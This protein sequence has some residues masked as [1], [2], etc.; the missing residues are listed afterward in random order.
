VDEIAI[1]VAEPRLAHHPLNIHSFELGFLC[2]AFNRLVLHLRL[3]NKIAIITGAGSGIGKA[4]TLAFSREGAKVTVA[5][6]QLERLK[7]TVRAVQELG[8]EAIAVQADISKVE[9]VKELVE[10]CVNAF[11]KLDL[12]YNNAGYG[13][14]GSITDAE[15]DSWDQVLNTNLKGTFMCSKYAIREIKKQGSGSVINTSSVMGLTGGP[16]SVAYCASKGGIV[17]MTR[18]MACD[19][20]PWGIRVNCICPGSIY[21]TRPVEEEFHTSGDPARLKKFYEKLYPMGRLGGPEEVA[22]LAVF[23]ASDESSFITGQI[24]VIDGGVMAQFP[25]AYW[26]KLW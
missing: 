4:G 8:G 24:F 20:A 18:A 26:P 17:N 11:G 13:I 16:A 15:E 22:N 1:A 2:I 5:G 19:C 14:G 3:Q 10:Q 9:D 21:P 12:L 7:E 23:L 25:E 6:R